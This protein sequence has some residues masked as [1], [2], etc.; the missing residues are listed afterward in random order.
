MKTLYARKEPST[1]EEVLKY[2]PN[3][4]VRDIVVFRDRAAKSPVKRFGCNS[5]ITRQ[6]K[7]IIIKDK[8]YKLDW[9]EDV[10]N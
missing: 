3:K 2:A 4:G 8:E 7:R 9:I 5:G 1:A 10:E 6:A